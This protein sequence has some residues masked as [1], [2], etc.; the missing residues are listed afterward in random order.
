MTTKC[1]IVKNALIDIYN[2]INSIRIKQQSTNIHFILIAFNDI[3]AIYSSLPFD[4]STLSDFNLINTVHFDSF[5]NFGNII[6][7]HIRSEGTTN[8]HSINQSDIFIDNCISNS[9]PDI[10]FKTIKYVMSDGKQSIIPNYPRNTLF[11]NTPSFDYSLGIGNADDYDKDVLSNISTTFISGID[12]E[13]IHNSI[14]GNS[15]NHSFSLVNNV[16]ISIITKSPI[17][18][19]SQYHSSSIETSPPVIISNSNKFKYRITDTILSIE[20]NSISTTIE[21]II[22]EFFVD[23]SGSMDETINNPNIHFSDS[24]SLDNSP[25]YST[26]D[27]SPPIKLTFEPITTNPIITDKWYKHTL[28]P[29]TVFTQLTQIYINTLIPNND[30]YIEIQYTDNNTSEQKTETFKCVQEQSTINNADINDIKLCCELQELLNYMN[31]NINQHTINE[32]I[33]HMSS[34]IST[35]YYDNYYNSIICKPIDTYTPPQI[36]LIATFNM[37]RKMISNNTS[38]STKLLND[39]LLESSN[40]IT[41][42]ASILFSQ[43]LSANTAIATPAWNNICSICHTNNKQIIFIHICDD[44][45]LNNSCSKH[46][47]HCCACIQCTKMMFFNIDEKLENKHIY[48]IYRKLLNNSTFNDSQLIEQYFIERNNNLHSYEH[49]NRYNKQCPLCRKYITN[50]SIIDIS[51]NLTNKCIE[52]HCNNQANYFSTQCNHVTFCNKCFIHKKR[53]SLSLICSCG[54]NISLSHHIKFYL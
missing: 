53:N 1:N 34:I 40:I 15:F 17:I 51:I 11:S 26:D 43:Q 24:N 27:I 38:L 22:F 10:S 39:M 7:K 19:S 48:S 47:N 50:I 6:L 20:Y 42:S 35:D 28:S 14:I 9:H 12:D 46:C 3:A 13:I 23:I 5:S 52:S 37:I 18:H 16:S 33:E 54:K 44:D 2:I 8:L 31:N 21:P 4:P 25:T 49:F 36:Q 30:I 45:C 32:Y 41:Q 29:L